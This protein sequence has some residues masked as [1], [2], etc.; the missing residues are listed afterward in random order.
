MVVNI[1]QT[2]TKPL[3]NETNRNETPNTAL[4]YSITKLKPKTINET[5]SAE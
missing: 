1:T 5:R 3:P 2:K 4:L